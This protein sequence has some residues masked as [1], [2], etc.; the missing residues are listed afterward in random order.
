MAPD[1][2]LK[3]GLTSEN[4][5][6]FVLPH[7][8]QEG[9]RLPESHGTSLGG[10]GGQNKWHTFF[11]GSNLNPLEQVEAVQGSNLNPPEQGETVRGSNLNPPEQG[12]TVRGSNLNPPKQGDAAVL[13]V[14]FKLD[15]LGHSQE[16]EPL[17][18][19]TLSLFNCISQE[20]GAMAGRTGQDVQQKQKPSRKLFDNKRATNQ[21]QISKNMYQFRII[22]H[23]LDR[24]LLDIDFLCRLTLMYMSD[25]TSFHQTST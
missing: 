8:T 23:L 18:V 25:S 14:T 6:L 19:V 3:L 13:G 21:S 10:S 4:S 12:E 15:Y 16:T 22:K 5:Q 20:K 17:Y 2:L 24:A 9:D 11:G 7:P 1:L